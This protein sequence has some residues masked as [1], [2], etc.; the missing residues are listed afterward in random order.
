MAE[1]DRFNSFGEK[2]KK[3]REGTIYDKYR[4]HPYLTQAE[5][6]QEVYRASNNTEFVSMVIKASIYDGYTRDDVNN[7]E[8]GKR[9]ITNKDRHLVKAMLRVLHAY[10]GV[11]S[12]A[13]ANELFSSAGLMHL[14][15]DEIA[16]IEPAWL[17]KSTADLQDIEVIKDE[18]D[19]VDLGLAPAQPDQFVGRDRDMEN[20]KS[21]LFVNEKGAVKTH[22]L[23]A[24]RGWPG[25]GKTTLA[26]ALANDTEVRHAYPDGVLWASLG[27]RPKL[28]PILLGWGRACRDA[29]ILSSHNVAEAAAN[30][31]RVLRNKR[32]LLVVDDIWKSEDA[33]PFLAAGGNCATLFTTRRPDIAVSI[34]SR[35]SQVY[36][37]NLLEKVYSLALLKELA[38]DVVERHPRE[39]E[40]LIENL[41]GLP[42]AIQ[43]AGRMLQTEFLAGLDVVSLMEAMQK[44]AI[45]L[46]SKAPIDQTDLQ[47]E[48]T[49][50]VA[51]VMMKSLDCLDDT[52]RERY[53]K[54]GVFAEAPAVI[55][56]D[57]LEGVW[58]TDQPEVTVR[59]LVGHGL[60]ENTGY[61]GEYRIHSM[62]KLLC[63]TL[64]E[65]NY[66]DMDAGDQ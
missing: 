46:E 32:C 3:L 6:G 5:F 64:W 21:R 25:V 58:H 51:A 10:K 38:G 11:E 50:T 1:P 8:R 12:L 66:P 45:L 65:D 15:P 47:R 24:M 2:L 33:A 16:Q 27:Q 54:L 55:T 61:P 56:L 57:V 60:L 7:W 34:V 13:A 19:F 23:A 43:V 18:G 26:S 62:L 31:K 36:P 40:R 17:T 53:A 37:V 63:R 42:L 52:T 29:Q 22:V 4:A 20:V 14:E 44:D 41:D 59:Q 35:S 49:P 9:Q 48:T 39:C 30:L 28:L